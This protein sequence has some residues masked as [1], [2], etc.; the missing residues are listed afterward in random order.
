MSSI[1]QSFRV[2]AF[3]ADSWIEPHSREFHDGR[4]R[5]T[6]GNPKDPETLCSNEFFKDWIEWLRDESSGSMKK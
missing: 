1:Q 2:A 3:P 5:D 4:R 6:E